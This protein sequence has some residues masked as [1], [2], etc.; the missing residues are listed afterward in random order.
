[1]RFVGPIRWSLLVRCS[2]LGC[3][4]ILTLSG[5]NSSTTTSNPSNPSSPSS[6]SNPGG[7]SS[8]SSSAA[9]V[10]VTS[11][12]STAGVYQIAAYA[13]GANGQ[14]TAVPGSPFNQNVGSMAAT[15]GY[16]LAA[17]NSGSDINT[18][19]IGSN[20]AL[21]LG[22][23]FDYSQIAS[24]MAS[25]FSPQTG[26]T[27]SMG[28]DT[29]DRTGQSLY[30]EVLCAQT[31]DNVDLIA[32]F[33]FDSSNGTLNYLG[34]ANTGVTFNYPALPFL[35]NDGYAY[36]DNSG[37]C[38]A[39]QGRLYTFARSNS[40]LLTQVSSTSPA[41]P[42]MPPGATAGGAG[43]FGYV[44]TDVAADTTNHLAVSED[45]CFFLNGAGQPYQL[46]AYTVNSDGSL[47]TTDTYATMPSTTIAPAFLEISPSGTLLA[48]GGLPGLEIFHFN[49]SSS[50]TSFTGVLTTDYIS[51]IA[52]DSSNHLYAL[53]AA[54]GPT[55]GAGKLHVFTVS[56]SG[57]TEA[58]GSPYTIQNPSQLAVASESQ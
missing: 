42:A 4:A 16:L 31:S 2:L 56:D 5:C 39:T 19:T 43:P 40:G 34:D 17:T 36:Q 58:P 18:Y 9:Y 21:T 30:A 10:Y 1:V 14:L 55:G 25:Q 57:A 8:S 20:G 52:W 37:G 7:S 13:A 49:G 45:A 29:F 53:V 47:T 6:P 33:A 22:P 3:A 51:A 26:F 50:I 38:A 15:S 35:G 32:S 28:V 27:C 11:E 54:P 41:G 24:Q 48:V 23:Q 12:T 44:A 46:A